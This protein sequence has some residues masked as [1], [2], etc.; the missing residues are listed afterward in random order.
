MSLMYAQMGLAAASTLGDFATTSIQAKM[1]EAQRAFQNHMSDLSAARSKNA[2]TTNEVR[3]QDAAVRADVQIQKIALSDQANAEVAAAAAG[4]AGNSV[5]MVMSDLR[6]SAGGAS[7]ANRRNANQQ[8]IEMGAQRQSVAIAQVTNK[9]IQ[10]IPK[11]SI[12]SL[13][14]GGAASMIDIYDSN[15]PD[16]QGLLG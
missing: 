9:N 4:T 5:D 12:G 10:I 11:P 7:Y 3:T 14:L 13:L 2:I 8:M 16:G 1:Q 6:A 15:Q